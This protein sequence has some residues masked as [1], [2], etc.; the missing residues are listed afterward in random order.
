[1]CYIS[2]DRE[3]IR[4]FI[5]VLFVCL[6]Q[7]ISHF[8]YNGGRPLVSILKCGIWCIFQI[9]FSFFQFQRFL[10]AIFGQGVSVPGGICSRG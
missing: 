4:L 10:L 9:T 8:F 5:D 7:E 2:L 1:M 6:D 3:N